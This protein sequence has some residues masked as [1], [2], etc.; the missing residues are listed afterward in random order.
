V[1]GIY[2][3]F[4]KHRSDDFAHARMHVCTQSRVRA[5]MHTHISVWVQSHA[6]QLQSEWGL[7]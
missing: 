4:Q 3:F 5:H 2:S 6:K 1:A 7:L